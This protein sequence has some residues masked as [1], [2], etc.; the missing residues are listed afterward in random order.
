MAII[1][2]LIILL[3]SFIFN[4]FP[5]RI[6]LFLGKNIGLFIF[7]F[8]PIRKNIAYTNI[9]ENFP[10]LDSKDHKLILKNNKDELHNVISLNFGFD[11]LSEEEIDEQYEHLKNINVNKRSK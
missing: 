11:K 1:S 9:R 7:I 5:R 2:Y 10:N 3:V 6:S 4:L 8:F